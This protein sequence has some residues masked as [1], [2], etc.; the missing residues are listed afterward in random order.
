MPNKNSPKS[1]ISEHE[2]TTVYKNTQTGQNWL[3]SNVDFTPETVIHPFAAKEISAVPT[4]LTVQVDDNKHITLSPDFL[5]NINHSCS[6]N[7]LFDTATMQLVC[8]RDIH[9][10]DEITFFYPSSEWEMT[11]S[12]SCHCGTKACL[13]QIDGAYHLS[14]AT[15]K[16]YRLT[17][18]IKRKIKET[19][20]LI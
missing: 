19:A 16:K 17:D 5:K 1:L 12:F 2:F 3:C 8:I 7:A 10:G 20:D 13:G 14:L 4:Y 9:A 11:Q 15:L 6:P 18:Y